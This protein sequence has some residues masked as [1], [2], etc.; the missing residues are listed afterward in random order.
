MWSYF[1]FWLGTK[2]VMLGVRVMD[3]KSFEGISLIMSLDKW[4]RDIINKSHYDT[5]AKEYL[6]TNNKVKENEELE[7]IRKDYET[8]KDI[9]R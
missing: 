4:S 7:K 2:F 1:R 6:E 9:S 5:M 8:K 3:K